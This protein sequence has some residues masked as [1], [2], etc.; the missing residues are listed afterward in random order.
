[1]DSIAV[2]AD[3]YVF[4]DKKSDTEDNECKHIESYQFLGI[5]AQ[6]C[7]IKR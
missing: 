4:R 3:I 2:F 1:M 7:P 5:R 6:L